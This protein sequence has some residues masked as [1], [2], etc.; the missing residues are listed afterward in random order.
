MTGHILRTPGISSMIRGVIT[1][2]EFTSEEQK[3]ACSDSHEG[4]FCRQPAVLPLDLSVPDNRWQNSRMACTDPPL[5]TQNDE[6]R[7]IKS[8]YYLLKPKTLRCCIWRI[9]LLITK[10]HPV[11]VVSPLV[12]GEES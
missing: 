5:Y 6:G 12:S 4:S 9:I 1:N 11:C 10:P 7:R 8:V 2:D 3:P